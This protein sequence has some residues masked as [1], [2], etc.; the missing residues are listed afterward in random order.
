MFDMPP[1]E[2]YTSG[3]IALLGD[4]AHASTS[5]AGAG[6]GMAIEDAFILSELLSDSS[7]LSLNDVP[8]V[9]EAY[10]IVRRPR[11]QKLVQYSRESSML[12]QMRHPRIEDDIEKIREELK[13]RQRWIWDIDLDEHL[14]CAKGQLFKSL[15]I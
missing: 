7:V 15:K 12:F 10:D 13:T 4:A 8:S 2:S 9:L 14:A 6:A 1:T 3:H 11:T 5:Q